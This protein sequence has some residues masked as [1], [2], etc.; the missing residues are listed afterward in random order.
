MGAQSFRAFRVFRGYKVS[1]N[2]KEAEFRNNKKW[3]NFYTEY[4]YLSIWK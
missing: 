1:V 2:V 4:P 3:Y